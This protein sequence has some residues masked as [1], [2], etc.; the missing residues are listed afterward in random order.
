MAMKNKILIISI[1]FS[2]L[3]YILLLKEKIEMEQYINRMLQEDL[4]YIQEKNNILKKDFNK[5]QLPKVKTFGLFLNSVAI[6]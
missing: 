5:S 1:A 6:V 4:L 2:L 3:F